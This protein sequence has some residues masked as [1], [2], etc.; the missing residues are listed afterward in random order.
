MKKNFIKLI[1][2]DKVKVE[3]SPYDLS[4]GR[5]TFRG[6]KKPIEEGNLIDYIHNLMNFLIVGKITKYVK[7]DINVDDIIV[8]FYLPNDKSEFYINITN[9]EKQYMENIGRIETEKTI[10]KYREKKNTK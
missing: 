1:E 10:K 6:T 5:I 2:G 4:K 8:R 9:E 7:K 3:L